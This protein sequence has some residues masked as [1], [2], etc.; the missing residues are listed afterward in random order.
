MLWCG[1]DIY[2]LGVNWRLEGTVVITPRIA[3]NDSPCV[4]TGITDVEVLRHGALVYE[5]CARRT[6]RGQHGSK[7]GPSQTPGLPGESIP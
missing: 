2:V 7:R 3:D 6:G 1:R 4:T 5:P